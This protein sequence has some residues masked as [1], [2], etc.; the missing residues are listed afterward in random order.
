MSRITGQ[1]GSISGVTSGHLVNW[2]V[3]TEVDITDYVDA[4]TLEEDSEESH[5][6][7]RKS[8]GATDWSGSA[9]AN[10]D[11]DDSAPSE[12]DEIDFVGTEEEGRDWSGDA[13]INGVSV[14]VELDSEDLVQYEISFEGNGPLDRP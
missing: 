11:S 3:D 10:V 9:T 5:P 12:G 14:G 13:I 2:E 4:G 8:I 1:E 7:K 6:A